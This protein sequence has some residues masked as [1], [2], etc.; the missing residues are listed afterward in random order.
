MYISCGLSGETRTLFLYPLVLILHVNYHCAV[1]LPGGICVWIGVERYFPFLV[2]PPFLLLFYSE[3]C[4]MPFVTTTHPRGASFLLRKSW[5]DM[6]VFW[7]VW[8]RDGGLPNTYI[9]RDI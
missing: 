6:K 9:E 7:S 5:G 2:V 8:W 1:G 4:M 3:F